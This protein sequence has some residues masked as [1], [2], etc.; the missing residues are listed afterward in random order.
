M[1]PLAFI[2][3]SA[4]LASI[5]VWI[6]LFLFRGGFWR[7]DQT[8]TDDAARLADWPEVIAIIPARDEAES[9]AAVIDAHQATSYPGSFSIVL[10]DDQSQDGT[11]ALARAAASGG[12]RALRI[13]DAPD[14]EP[15][16]S[17]K[18]WA[19]NAGLQEMERAHSDARYVLLCDADILFEPEA[20]ERLVSKAVSDD[21]ALVSVMARLDSRGFWGHLLIP[22]FV[23]FFQK[24]YPFPL[25]NDPKSPVGGAAGGC[26]LVRRDALSNIGGVEGI[27]GALIDDCAFAVAIKGTPPIRRTWLGFASGIT[28]LRDNRQIG[29]I[30]TMVART[31]YTQLHHSPFL[32][33]VS[34]IG[35]A[36]TYL[37]GPFALAVGFVKG[38]AISAIAG[39]VA[40]LLPAI[41]YRPTLARY[42]LNAL[43]SLTLPVA[44]FFYSMMTV[45]SAI[46][47][48]RGKGGRWKGRNYNELSG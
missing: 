21:R 40:W 31:A 13:I 42:P 5:A 23:F 35:M 18:L 4:A 15:G 9:I 39:S 34:V 33:A 19:V 25:V 3:T 30:W 10:V 11:A 29:S 14:L 26:M 38:A 16:W 48:W 43:W 8:L 17:G 45:T 41:A 37:A 6:G 12:H 24:L 32:L 28:S 2:A 22:P 46:N 44:A 36:L 1:E 20:L 7:A 47:H 27:R